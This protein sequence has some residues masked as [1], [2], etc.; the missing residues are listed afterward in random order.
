M[1]RDG[2]LYDLASDAWSPMSAAGAPS[3]RYDG[4]AVWTGSR[5]IVWG[6]LELIGDD[7]V[8]VIP[9]PPVALAKKAATI[10]VP[11]R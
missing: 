5:M 9:V 10:S 8:A 1:L 3:A 7:W 4:T 2:A 6:G 11:R